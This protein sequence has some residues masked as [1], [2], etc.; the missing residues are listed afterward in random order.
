MSMN[1]GVLQVGYQQDT[2]L[3]RIIGRGIFTNCQFLKRHINE[4][5][6]QGFKKVVVDSARC[7]YMDSSFL[8][9]LTGIAIRLRKQHHTKL[10]I[11]NLSPKVK[12][13]LFTIGLNHIFKV[14]D[15]RDLAGFPVTTSLPLGPESASTLAE[16]MLEAHAN[17][18]KINQENEERFKDVRE[19]LQQE[20]KKN[21]ETD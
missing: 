14:T 9:T 6:D 5:L 15:Q 1:K 12:E 19:A 4:I 17:L 18:V 13:T 21:K 16:S 20:V 2:V 7:D 10:E 8:G 3:V 11:T